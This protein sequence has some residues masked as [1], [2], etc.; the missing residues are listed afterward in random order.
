MVAFGKK[1]K[2]RQILEWQG[3]VEMCIYNFLHCLE[4]NS[5]WFLQES[6]LLKIRKEKM[7]KMNFG[8]I[9]MLSTYE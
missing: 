8:Y 4:F 5:F 9:I 3:Y 7:Y 1:L 6:F 2:E